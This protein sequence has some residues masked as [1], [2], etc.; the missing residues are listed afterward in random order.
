MVSLE[1]SL[2]RRHSLNMPHRERN[3]VPDEWT[4]ERKDAMSLTF[5]ASVWNTKH[6][7]ISRGQRMR[8]GV[9]S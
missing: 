9:Y 4:S 6:A 7:I 2:E 3:I 1:L 8:D 5:I